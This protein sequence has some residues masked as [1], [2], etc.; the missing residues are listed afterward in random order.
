MF[1][2]KCGAHRDENDKFCRNCGFEFTEK[3]NPTENEEPDIPAAT[4]KKAKFYK[5]SL[6]VIFCSF[7]VLMLL[8]CFLPVTAYPFYGGASSV[9]GFAFASGMTGG[10]DG[11]W[12]STYFIINMFANIFKN[13]D[14]VITPCA[15]TVFSLLFC[16]CFSLAFAIVMF[17]K[18]RKTNAGAEILL[19][20]FYLFL[21]I[22][23]TVMTLGVLLGYKVPLGAAPVMLL[24][25]TI[26]AFVSSVVLY[27][28]RKKFLREKS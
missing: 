9:Y 3:N 7:T 10:L 19:L 1:C 20:I 26:A 16:I 28:K 6:K 25:L 15:L 27:I 21:I 22:I 24:L 13:V 12:D 11:H 4:L 17:T 14:F 23:F 2:P 8:F 5:Y 18:N